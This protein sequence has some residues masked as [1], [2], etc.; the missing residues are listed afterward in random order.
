MEFTRQPATFLLLPGG[1]GA[2]VAAQAL[3]R[4]LDLMCQVDQFGLQAADLCNAS[5]RPLY[6]LK[7]APAQ[8][9]GPGLQRL[10]RLDD[11]A[12]DVPER[13]ESQQQYR[14][15]HQRGVLGRAQQRGGDMFPGFLNDQR[16]SQG[17]HRT[18]GDHV[19]LAANL[20][21][22]GTALTAQRFVNAAVLRQVYTLV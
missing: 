14:D 12:G 18:V 8:F 13:Q 4:R 15:Q 21:V 17:E 3:L 19:F 7:V 5:H 22:T 6:G 2:N 16:P 20:N 10:E 11:P 9:G 1:D